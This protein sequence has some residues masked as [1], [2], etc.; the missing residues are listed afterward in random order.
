MLTGIGMFIWQIKN[1]ESGDVNA[2]VKKALEANLSHVCIKVADTIWG[3]N[4]TP[5]G[6]DLVPE[7]ANALHLAGIEVWGWH[8]VK[9]ND[10]LGEARIAIKR[11]NELKLDGYIVDAEN[12]YKA[13]G[14]AQAAET[15]MKEL[16]LFL[17]IPIALSSYRYPSYHQNFPF[18]AF[19][20][21]CDFNMPQ[22]YWEESHNAD[23]QLV[24][25]IKEFNN[26][27]LVGFIRPVVPTG[28]AYGTSKWKAIPND[29]IEFFNKAQELKL[30][31]V[32]YYSWDYATSKGNTEM[33]DTIKKLQWIIEEKKMY[34]VSY[35]VGFG[36]SSV[37]HFERLSD[38]QLSN[39]LERIGNRV[40][41]ET[42]LQ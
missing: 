7:L 4:Y 10:P 22:V 39:Y 17:K 32:N 34:R 13:V 41:I 31:A 42:I 37:T 9:G 20:K 11:S 18:K 2:I 5:F 1:C 29:L 40:T 21:Y 28:S 38:I 35:S 33:W 8:Y 23:E 12:E 15:F 19:L 25:V 30:S 26:I 6:K 27:N 16:K 3:Y 36:G 24:R 14:K